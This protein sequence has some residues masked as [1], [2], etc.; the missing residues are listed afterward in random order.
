MSKIDSTV[1]RETRY[2]AVWVFLLSIVMQAVFLIVGKWDYTVLLGNL[3]SG[4]MAV[5]NF[6]LMGITVQKAVEKDEKDA[7]AMMKASQGMRTLMLFIVVVLG[8]TLPCFNS[9]AAVIPMFF[10]RIAIAIVPLRDRKKKSGE[11]KD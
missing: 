1:L 2:I 8:I 3:F 5:A 7:K 10:P 9:I 4:I 11:V 6:L